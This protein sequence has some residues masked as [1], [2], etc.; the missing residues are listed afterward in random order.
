M[1]IGFVGIWLFSILDSSQRAR[2]RPRRLPGAAGAV[3]DRH[4]RLGRVG[5]LSRLGRGVPARRCGTSSGLRA[6]AAQSLFV[7]E[8]PMTAA[9]DFDVPPFDTLNAAQQALVRATAGLV[10]FAADDPVLTPE[11]EPTHACLLV[12][13]HVRREAGVLPEATYGAGDAVR[14]ARA[15]RGARH[16]QRRWRWTRC[17]LADPEGHAAVAAVGQPGLLRRGVRRDRAP[18]VEAGGAQRAARVP[19]ADDGARARRLRAQALLRRRRARPGVGV[20]R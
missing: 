9:F 13:G 16:Q 14:R 20:P 6:S 7:S 1:T 11:M 10:R 19:V 2:S 17:G 4:R 8:P 15:A 18:P 12:E 3:R 5:P